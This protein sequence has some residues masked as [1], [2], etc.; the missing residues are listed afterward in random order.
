[1]QLALGPRDVLHVL[2]PVGCLIEAFSL[3][4]LFIAILGCAAAAL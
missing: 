2:S 3:A 1:M 4:L